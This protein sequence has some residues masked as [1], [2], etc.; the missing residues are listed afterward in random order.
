M[1][2]DI[3]IAQEAKI[4]NIMDIAKKIKRKDRSYSRRAL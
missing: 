1:K 4:V 3:Q 2:T